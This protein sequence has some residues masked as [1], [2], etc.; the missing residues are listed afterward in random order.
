MTGDAAAPAGLMTLDTARQ[1]REGERHAVTVGQVMLPL[2]QVAVVAADE[3]L[4]DLLPRV[5]PG[6]EHRVLVLDEDRVVGIVS[7]SDVSRT[8]TWLMPTT[9]HGRGGRRG[10]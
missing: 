3:P 6:A 4:A 5:E 9:W 10:V 8:G 1:V 2:S 7:A